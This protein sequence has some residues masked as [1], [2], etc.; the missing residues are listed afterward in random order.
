[1]DWLISN[2]SYTAFLFVDLI[3]IVTLVAAM[4]WVTRFMV[5]PVSQHSE[6]SNIE[7]GAAVVALMVAL[8]GVTSGSFSLT[9]YEEWFLVTSYGIL[10][11]LLLRLGVWIQDHVVIASLNLS[12]ATKHGNTSAAI[13]TGSHLIGTAIVIQSSMKWASQDANLGLIALLFGFVIS[14]CLLALET[15]LRLIWTGGGLLVAI[16][17]KQLP[18]VLKAAFQHIG[19]ALAISGSAPFASAI[20]YQLQLAV[21]AWLFSSVVFLLAYLALSELC[22][23]FVLPKGGA[24]EGGR[25]ALEGAIYLGWG[26]ILPALAS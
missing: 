10:A 7:T 3:A 8:T 16:N 13:V 18:V 2:P 6:A 5:K 15:K 9:L 20:E 25:P 24:F 26:F 22:V 17:K 12:S 1:M 19:A 4:R 14:Q 23:R 11:I 21:V